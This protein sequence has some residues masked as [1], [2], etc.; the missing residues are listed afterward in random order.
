MSSSFPVL[1]KNRLWHHY[2]YPE[3][4]TVETNEEW[5][6][7]EKI[8]AAAFEVEIQKAIEE[9]ESL[10]W[11]FAELSVEEMAAHYAGEPDP[12]LWEAITSLVSAEDVEHA[13][14]LGERMM[15][16]RDEREDEIARMSREY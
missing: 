4:R 13:E 15:D 8:R 11:A 14:F 16:T 5:A 3:T 9:A 1:S 6:E 10:A 7:K 2:P 12:R